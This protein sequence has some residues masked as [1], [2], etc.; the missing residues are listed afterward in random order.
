MR[1]MM[2]LDWRTKRDNEYTDGSPGK[3]RYGEGRVRSICFLPVFFIF[4]MHETSIVYITASYFLA[5]SDE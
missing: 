1:F 4:I 3:K 2:L 5:V